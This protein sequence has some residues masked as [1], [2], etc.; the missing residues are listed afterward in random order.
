MRILIV[1]DDPE[2]VRILERGFADEGI[3][4]EAAP[5]YREGRMRAVMGSWDVMVLDILLPGGSGMELCRY[6]RGRD[7]RTPI[8]MLTARDAVPDRVEGLE[9]G[10]DDYLTKPFDFRELLARVRALARRPPELAPDT[11]ELDALSVD[12]RSR[13]VKRGT[14]SIRLTAK[15]WD[16]LELFVRNVDRVVSRGEIT[17]YVW[18][19]NHD[20]FSNALE[21]LIARLRKKIDAEGERPLIHT[22]RG[23]G[24]RFGL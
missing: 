20:P 5:T 1:E 24:Y 10:A 2:L 22:I 16:L 9:S 23:A 14:R 6:V 4:V 7:I 19:E 11:F 21:M 15:E 13:R 17:S 18:D 3:D 12:L 8:L